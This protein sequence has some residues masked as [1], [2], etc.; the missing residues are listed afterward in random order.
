[1]PGWHNLGLLELFGWISVQ[2]GPPEPGEGW[3]I[4]HIWRTPVGDALLAA[5][6][7]GFF[8]DWEKYIQL[9]V[10]GMVPPGVLQPALQPYLPAWR[11][12]LAVPTWSFR[13]G[14]HVF[15]V[16]LDRWLWRR[17]AI[18]ADAPVD[19]LASA[20]LDAYEFDHDH[21][22]EFSYLNR[23]G[24]QERVTHPQLDEGPWASEV[25]RP[26]SNIARGVVGTNW[27]IWP[28]SIHS[29]TGVVKDCT[30]VARI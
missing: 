4:E 17:I 3:R 10:E 5:L 22:Y 20:I 18:P 28:M 27:R 8:G 14:L 21:L 16:S 30:S 24:V 25:A 29:D 26:R 19:A 12:T 6:Y 23:F 13:D 7:D 11:N 9:D 1:M 15:K 2:H